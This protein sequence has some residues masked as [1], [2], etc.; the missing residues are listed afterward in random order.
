[1]RTASS[2]THPE[3]Q[4]GEI[5]LTNSHDL[6]VVGV[7]IRNAVTIRTAYEGIGW[8]TKRKGLTAYDVNGKVLNGMFP[9][10]VQIAEIEAED[11]S[12][13]KRLLG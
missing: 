5:F 1:M 10:F 6:D 9:V 8:K 13:I 3:Q 11:P 2:K 4:E 12:I 7:P